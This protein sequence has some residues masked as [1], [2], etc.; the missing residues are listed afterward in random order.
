MTI[1]M[2]MNRSQI[3]IVDD[4]TT[5]LKAVSFALN[6]NISVLTASTVEEA[7]QLLMKF[8]VDTIVTDYRMNSGDGHEIVEIAKTLLPS[9][10][11]IL[12]TAYADKDIAIR[13]ANLQVFAFLEK[14]VALSDLLAT[15]AN[16]V[17]SKR[18]AQRS[19]DCK[20]E[21]LNPKTDFHL[22][23]N[24]STV[25][26][27]G[28][29][30]EL[31]KIEFQIFDAL[32][33]SEGQRIERDALIQKVWGHA[34]TSHNLLDTHLRNMRRKLDFLPKHLKSVWGMGYLFSKSSSRE[35]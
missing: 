4:D 30:Y 3:L 32:F 8:P 28:Q 11:V 14:P 34:K 23:Q 7:K 12:I 2:H 19:A 16:A 6:E 25:H 22:D 17:E 15:I 10:P 33:K 13:S 27:H 29:R 35:H 20:C 9:P 18:R 24:D 1:W 21:S 5:F 31:T 26:Y